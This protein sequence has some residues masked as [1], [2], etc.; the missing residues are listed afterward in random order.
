M[1]TPQLPVAP[2]WFRVTWVTAG[3]AMLT[4]PHVDG[5]LRGNLWYIRGRERDLVVDTGNGIAPV[6]PVLE[7]LSYGRRKEVIAVATHSHIDHIGG[8]HEFEHR[9]FHPLEREAAATMNEDAPLATA[10]WSAQLKELLADEGFILPPVLVDAVPNKAFDPLTFRIEPVAATR[11]V[12]GG[13]VIDLGDRQLLVVHL[14][15]HTP[16]SIGLYD[17]ANGALFSGDAIYDGGL[18][19]TLPESDIVEYVRTMERLQKLPVEVV[20]PGHDEPFGGERLRQ[21]CEAYIRRR[22]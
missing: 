21:L 6:R 18:I 2:D 11:L 5:L 16:G 10:T 9:L 19:D 14:P 12:E 15:G 1:S 7:R 20:Y 4:E 8:L 22:G 3:I 17:E 13:D